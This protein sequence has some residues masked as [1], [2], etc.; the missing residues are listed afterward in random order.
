MELVLELLPDQPVGVA[1]ALHNRPARG[2]F[3]THE[4]RDAD[5]TFVADHR[6]LRRRAVGQHVQQRHDGIGRKRHVAQEIAGLVQDL[7]ER[8]RHE[9]QV[10]VQSFAFRRGQR[11]QQVVLLRIVGR[12]GHENRHWGQPG[13]IGVYE[14]RSTVRS[15]RATARNPGRTAPQ[16]ENQVLGYPASFPNIVG[17]GPANVDLANSK[18]M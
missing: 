13:G 9:P 1:G 11:S 14:Y 17:H 8:Q 18:P 4:Q 7:A 10:R 3:P 5:E 15:L 6:D 16:A 2:G 12:A